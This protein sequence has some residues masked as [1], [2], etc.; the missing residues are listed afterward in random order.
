M[1]HSPTTLD[2][3]PEALRA[4]A[5]KLDAFVE[6]DLRGATGWTQKTVESY[7]KRGLIEAYRIGKHFV[8]PKA[9]ILER[10]RKVRGRIGAKDVL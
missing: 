3:V 5:D 9:P 10:G 2:A 8:Y 7:R 4:V 6:P 1:D